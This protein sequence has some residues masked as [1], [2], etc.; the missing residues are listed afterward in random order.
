MKPE[1]SHRLDGPKGLDELTFTIYTNKTIHKSANM[2]NLILFLVVFES[3]E[4]VF[5]WLRNCIFSV[6]GNGT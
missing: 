2:P 1:I 5:I 3:H 6:G 4:Y